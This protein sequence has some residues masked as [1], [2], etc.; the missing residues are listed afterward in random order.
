MQ[1]KSKKKTLPRLSVGLA[2]LFAGDMTDE[3]MCS[4]YACGWGDDYRTG[5]GDREFR[6]IPTAVEALHG[7]TI[8]HVACGDR[9]SLFA[10]CTFTAHDYTDVTCLFQQRGPFL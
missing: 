5:L 6:A 10:T 3:T 4:L 8:Y 7:Q 9:H 1:K 2:A